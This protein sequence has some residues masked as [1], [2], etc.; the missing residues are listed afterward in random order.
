M[1]FKRKLLLAVL[2][3]AFSVAMPASALDI[4]F[5]EIHPAGY[6]TVVAEQNMG[7]SWNSQQRRHHLQDVRRR[8]AGLGRK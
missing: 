5:A 3:F 4:K 8:R 6:P 7:K 2:P 1:T